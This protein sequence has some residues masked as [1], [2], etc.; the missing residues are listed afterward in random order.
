MTS[1]FDEKMMRRCLEL[2]ESA[3]GRTSPNP[4]VGAVLVDETGALVGEGF[5]PK[6]GEPHAEVFALRQAGKAAAGG[7]LYVNLEPCS[8]SGRTPPC[9]DSVIESGVKRVVVGMQDPNP[10]VCGQGIERLRAAGITV[11]FSNL[12]NECAE[13]NRAFSKFIVSK[14]PWLTLKM[15]TSLDGRIADRESKSRWISGRQAR[16]YVQQ[17]RNIYDCVLVGGRTAQIDDPELNVRE[18]EGARDPHRAVIDPSLGIRPS[19]RLC[20]HKEGSSSWTVI[21]HSA[22]EKELAVYP[23]KVMLVEMPAECEQSSLRFALSWLAGNDVLSVFCEGGGR[24]AAALL[25]EK[26][27]DEISWILAPKLFCD[28][29]AIPSLAGKEFRD[30]ADLI[31]ICEPSY[32]QLGEDILVSGKVRY[33]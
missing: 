7:T 18:I 4:L 28:A 21:F 17:M 30:V 16:H 14:L 6:A 33:K 2:A 29:Q 5:H 25:E 24:L 27:V 26:L 19:A 9:V 11:D 10:K 3:Q 1:A 23:E 15:A 12:Q 13:L 32:T 31:E 8:H 20:K 22:M